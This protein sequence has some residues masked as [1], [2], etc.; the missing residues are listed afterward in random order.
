MGCGRNDAY[1]ALYLDRVRIGDIVGTSP[2]GPGV[3]LVKEAFGKCKFCHLS[4]VLS[5]RRRMKKKKKKNTE[6]PS[7][8]SQMNAT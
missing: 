2:D 4:C 1:W 8:C 7:I 6:L 5:S 3:E